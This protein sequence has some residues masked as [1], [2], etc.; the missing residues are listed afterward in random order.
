[1]MGWF[2]RLVAIFNLSLFLLLTP[3]VGLQADDLLGQ[4]AV[5]PAVEQRISEIAQRGIDSGDMPGCVVCFGDSQRVLFLKSYGRRS[6]EPIDEPMSVDT[7][8]D[9]ASLTKPVAT[10]SAIVKLMEAGLI[11]LD[12]PIS[13]HWKGFE[14]NGK[15]HVTILDCLVHR[16][17]LIP[18]NALSDYRNG[19]ITAWEKIHQLPLQ[20]P[21]H[22]RFQYSDV[23]FL[24]LGKVVEEITGRSL[25]EYVKSEIL[26]PCEMVDSDFRIDPSLV[27]RVAPTERRDGAW[28]RGTVHDPR[29]YWLGGVAGHAGLFSTANDLAKFSMMILNRGIAMKQDGTKVQVFQSQSVDAMFRPYDVHGDVRGLGWDIQSRYSRNKGKE[30]SMESIGHGGFTGTVL[31]IDRKRGMFFCF[32]SSRLHPDGKGNIN[33]IAGELWDTICD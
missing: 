15:E 27:Q 17:G 5:S 23:N 28:I 8:F 26:Q 3:H 14:Q 1:M 30:L 13:S 19:P 33:P 24:V 4:A 9:L 12:D 6:V 21:R 22:T 7:I 25:D 31:W 18:D 10:A 16:S 32:L 20:S 2:V 11:E 29:A